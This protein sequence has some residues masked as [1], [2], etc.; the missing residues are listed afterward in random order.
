MPGMP[1][2][3]PWVLVATHMHK[4]SWKHC[5]DLTEHLTQKGK[6][7]LI[8]STNDVVENTIAIFRLEAD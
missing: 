4:V 6:S 5:A 8:S 2:T 1:T 7:A 3:A